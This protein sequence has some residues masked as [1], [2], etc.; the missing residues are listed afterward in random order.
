M[1]GFGRASVNTKIGRFSIEIFSINRKFFEVSITG[2]PRSVSFLEME[3]R[4]K[5]KEFIH[6]GKV[7][8]QI[9]YTPDEKNVLLPSL[10]VLKSIK[11]GWKDRAKDL[12]LD[13]KQIDLN[14]L[15]KAAH[16]EINQEEVDIDKDTS[17]KVM[18]CLSKAVDQLTEMKKTEGSF[19]QKEIEK[20]LFSI[21]NNLKQIEGFS[22]NTCE[23]YQKK[24]V[25]K[26]EKAFS[27]QSEDKERLAKEAFIYAEKVD[28]T[29]EIARLHSH[30][31]QFSTYIKAEEETKGRKIDF[32]LQ[33]MMREISTIG[34]KGNEISIS[35][36]V[37]EMKSDLEKIR[38]QI[39]NIE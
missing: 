16:Y 18:E 6:R 39:Q 30:F 31:D 1:T 37:V 5:V 7:S 35:S 15:L 19:L 11:Q 20:H 9:T 33:E 14:F 13:D 28:I 4:K 21:S 38:E 22:K 8:I 34:A 2:L 3:M 23:K 27:I 36:T 10:N 32:L 12:S 17:T 24:L 29:E 25:E 26:F